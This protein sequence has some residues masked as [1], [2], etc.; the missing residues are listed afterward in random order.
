MHRWPSAWALFAWTTIA[1]T[2]IAWTTVAWTTVGAARPAV[3]RDPSECLQSVDS[4]RAS[5][6]ERWAA[7]GEIDAA[8]FEQLRRLVESQPEA[9]IELLDHVERN[10]LRPA[11]A[12]A[13]LDLEG[14]ARMAIGD[15]PGAA[16]ALDRALTTDDGTT[17]ID[18]LAGG[19]SRR[20]RLDVGNGRLVRVAEAMLGAGREEEA[21]RALALALSLGADVGPDSRWER[22][23][24]GLTAVRPQPAPLESL[25]WF[26]P[27]PDLD[28]ELTDGESFS[29]SAARGKVLVLNFWATWCKPCIAE[30]GHLQYLYEQQRD[31]GLE[32][33]AVNAQ[34]PVHL[35]AP[36]VQELGLTMPIGRFDR[37]LDDAFE[38]RTLPTM[39]V[40]DRLGRLRGRWVG[41]EEGREREVID[42]VDALLANEPPRRQVADVIRGEG[43]LAVTWM[44]DIRA[45][46]EGIAVIPTETG[47]RIEVTHGIYLGSFLPDGSG[48]TRVD[49]SRLAGRLAGLAPAEDGSYRLYGFNPG[50]TTVVR[51]DMPAGDLALWDAPAPVFSLEVRDAEGGLLLGTRDGL[52]RV[53]SDGTSPELIDGFG[54]VTDIRRG[55][56]GLVVL[57]PGRRVSWLADDLTVAKHVDAPG[58]SWRLVV[59][60]D[61][62]SGPTLA[63]APTRVRSIA[64]GRFLRDGRQVAVATRDGQLVLLDADSGEERFRAVGCDVDELAAWDLDADGL[65][66]LIVGAG[67]ELAVLEAS[68]ETR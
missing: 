51:F 37:A 41:Y 32:I 48:D 66:E 36:Y 9:S 16:T 52:Y 60:G 44:R 6:F 53:G 28:V 57:E 56:G 63:T 49:G 47:P 58:H 27:L 64:T 67:S 24:G 62:P 21:R 38:V 13:L 59:V 68:A 23:Q 17:R 2:T 43:E 39:V 26:P 3:A 8:R 12:A 45:N 61:D 1:W 55:D 25:E 30:L 46:V 29:L 35:V 20:I 65:D 4:E 54:L 19:V 50:S 22:L 42:V 40:A 10:G 5:C 7:T 15:L 11:L 34:E 14:Q 33:L 31:S 18:W